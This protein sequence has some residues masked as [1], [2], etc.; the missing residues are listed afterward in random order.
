ML[1]ET[2]METHDDQFEAM[3]EETTRQRTRGAFAATLAADDRVRMWL[4]DP[5]DN[6]AGRILVRV[7]TLPGLRRVAVMPDVH[8]S[9]DV[10][11]GTVLGTSGVVYPAAIGGDIGCGMSTLRIRAQGAMTPDQCQNVLEH[12]RCSID[13]IVRRSASRAVDVPRMNLA[14]ESQEL[15]DHRLQKLA[16]GVGSRQVGTLGRG[17][18][19]VELQTDEQG[20]LW[21]LVHSGSRSM[22]Q[23][24]LEQAQRLA[25]HDGVRSAMLGLDPLSAS[26][27]NYLCWQDWC[28]RYARANRCRLLALAADGVRA[29]I[30]NS[31][32]WKRIGEA[33]WDSLIDTPHNFIRVETHAGEELIVHRKGAAPAS[34][35]QVGV[36]PG[37]AGTMSVHVE[38]RGESASLCSSS[39]G[40]GR[41]LSRSEARAH[42]RESD[43][44]CDMQGVTFD[45][46]AARSLRDESPRV[47]RDLRLVLRAQRDLVK[48]VRTLRPLISF[49]ASG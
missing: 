2:Q 26:G 41:V 44:R 49:K 28:V 15:Q 8:P 46:S 5:L 12:W 14:P 29:A 3:H 9:S 48:V 13:A 37:S 23:A 33:D 18:H 22:G 32:N 43:V 36:I 20:D 21:L 6:A 16:D 11:V 39:H 1:K 42:V 30:A 27:R 17:N 19:F 47:Y 38:G 24:V 40:A 7:Q 31:G 25:R 45:H 35:G 10:C 34:A 4:A